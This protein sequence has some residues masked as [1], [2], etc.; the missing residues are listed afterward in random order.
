MI[1]AASCRKLQPA[2]V[3]VVLVSGTEDHIP[4]RFFSNCGLMGKKQRGLVGRKDAPRV[5]PS[6]WDLNPFD[7]R[8]LLENKPG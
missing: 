1:Q 2:F 3:G 7:V 5:A 6:P 4:W 8:V